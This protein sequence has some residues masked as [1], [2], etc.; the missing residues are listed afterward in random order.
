MP[1]HFP[2]PLPLLVTQGDPAGIGPELAL[3]AWR[4]RDARAL[5]SFGWIG[6]P[7]ALR[8]AMETTGSDVPLIETDIGGVLP[9]F[10]RGLPVLPTM[11]KICGSRPGKPD[12]ESAA[13]TI[14]AIRVAVELVQ[15]GR[16][17]GLVTMPIAKHVLYQAGFTH[18]G[19]TEF[20]AELARKAGEDAP[21]PVMLIWSPLLAVVPVTIHIP[22]KDVPA[23]LDIELIVKTARIVARDYHSR[24]GI[25]RAR[26][27]LCG[28]NPHAGENGAMGDED[29]AIIAPAVA[30]LKA[31][32]IDASGPWPA[33]TMF[34]ERARA[35]YDVALGMYHDQ[36]LIPAKT[37]AF[38]EGVNVTL[39]L[40]FIR[41]SP[42][43][44]TAFDIAGKGLARPDSACAAIRLAGRL[45]VREAARR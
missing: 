13:S 38:D 42:D 21:L 1:S 41:T 29:A 19:H 18:P 35:G 34:H 16:A 28:L 25:E 39:G 40:P 17:G 20:L 45:A 27:A 8:M 30:Q 36:V 6:D 10:D 32:D 5:P 7:L 33:D 4:E 14:E 2:E 9:A 43:H 3:L 12:P 22:L 44:G 23:R 11:A 26:L 31:E 37:L 24:F 15:S